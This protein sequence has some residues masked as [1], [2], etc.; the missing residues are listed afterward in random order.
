MR[1]VSDSE[2]PPLDDAALRGI[3]EVVYRH[4]GIR[5]AASKGYFVVGRL[6]GLFRSLQC[7]S[8]G[9][10]PGRLEADPRGVE[11]LVQ[12]IVT[13]ET[14]FFR[15]EA[16]FLALREK[17]APDL[18]NGVPR[19]APLRVW[20]AG[21]STG[22][23]SYS[24][25]MALWD[26]VERGELDVQV[27][28]T[29]ISAASLAKAREGV[30]EPLELRRGLDP[31]ARRRFFTEQSGGLARVRD[32]IRRRVRFEPFNLLQGVPRERFHAVY[33]RNVAIYFDREG[34]QRLYGAVGAAVVPGGYLVLG[35]AE[36]LFPGVPGF[37]TVY[38]GR[39]LLFRRQTGE[40][41]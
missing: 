38:F 1:A 7:T 10:L 4:T 41:R 20:S 34:K 8:W 17:I 27:W 15:D 16:P 28:A 25:V 36:T 23:E 30:Y 11:S 33:C 2:L 37:E 19:P 18:V 14:S 35:A 31:D 12:A 24:I 5:L 39:S 26:R 3:A 32:E 9:E 40:P 13:G 21:C 29:D 6:R 22:Q